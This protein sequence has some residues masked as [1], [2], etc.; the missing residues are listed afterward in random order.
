MEPETPET[1][2][3]KDPRDVYEDYQLSQELR[4]QQRRMGAEGMADMFLRA[5][6]DKMTE[7]QR[8]L[9]KQGWVEMMVP[10]LDPLP[11]PPQWP[12]QFIVPAPPPMP[13][14]TFEHE[15][16]ETIM[17]YDW[18]CLLQRTSHL[19]KNKRNGEITLYKG[20]DVVLHLYAGPAADSFEAYAKAARDRWAGPNSYRGSIG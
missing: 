9:F 10:S 19:M 4:H 6:G 20:G 11:P 12:G 18:H 14:S 5:M 2:E 1:P 8:E 7:E 16:E 13:P 3:T 17:F 15:T